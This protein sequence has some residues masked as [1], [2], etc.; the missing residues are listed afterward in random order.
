MS[1]LGTAI[2]GLAIAVGIAG[3]VVAVVPGALLV[4]AAIAVWALVVG[5]TTALA[6]LVAATGLVGGAQVA[7]LLV[8]G[9]RLL[10]AGVP[11]RP[12]LAGTALAIV[13]FFVIPV[14][15]F[16][17][18]SRSA[19]S[20][21]NFAA[22]AGTPAPATRPSRPSAPSA[23]RSS[24][25]C[26]RRR[27]RPVSGRWPC[28]AELQRSRVAT[29]SATSSPGGPSPAD[30]VYNASRG[31]GRPAI[32]RSLKAVAR[33]ESAGSPGRPTPAIGSGVPRGGGA[34]LDQPWRD[35]ARPRRAP[36]RRRRREVS[37]A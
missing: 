5:S 11:G 18:A 31:N 10:D 16:F 13:G 9:R 34:E 17:P 1:D 33:R 37:A 14:V 15:G 27:S 35:L 32:P 36:G 8:P 7:K 22:S 4:W 19:S 21:R 28:S 24:S 30:L 12:I 29:L 25:S 6:A 20:S 23:S 3:V 2:V 26:P